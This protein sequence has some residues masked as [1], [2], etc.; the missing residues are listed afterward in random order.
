MEDQRNIILLHLLRYQNNSVNCHN[1]IIKYILKIKPHTSPLIQR[2]MSKTV[3]SLS[4]RIYIYLY[5]AYSFYFQR[6][7]VHGLTIEYTEPYP[8]LFFPNSTNKK[9]KT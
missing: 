7:W 5:I 6:H 4:L 2:Q 1:I 8:M 9:K 3:F